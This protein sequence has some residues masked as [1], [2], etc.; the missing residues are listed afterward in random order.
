MSTVVCYRNSSR[1]IC[2]CTSS[3]CSSLALPLCL[4]VICVCMI[5]NVCVVSILLCFIFCFSQRVQQIHDDC[6]T[7]WCGAYRVGPIQRLPQ[8]IQI[9]M[10]TYAPR[11]M[12][13]CVHLYF[14]RLILVCLMCFIRCKSFSVIVF[15]FLFFHRFCF[16]CFF[17]PPFILIL[18]FVHHLN[19]LRTVLSISLNSNSFSHSRFAAVAAIATLIFFLG[20]FI[21]TG[22]PA[23]KTIK[24]LIFICLICFSWLEFVRVC[25]FI[26]WKHSRN[27]VELTFDWISF[28]VCNIFNS[29]L[30][31]TIRLF[32]YLSC[33]LV[34]FAYQTFVVVNF[35]TEK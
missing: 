34:L 35:N 14:L 31:D 24:I 18:C 5:F 6:C 22:W 19:L 28:T 1:C 32:L 8:S 12:R 20:I 23:R 13:M 15:V 21:T 27:S 16:V 33:V 9:Q 3:S 26:Q 10:T 2:L 30:F 29:S 7:I 11:T 25:T 17:S 4:T